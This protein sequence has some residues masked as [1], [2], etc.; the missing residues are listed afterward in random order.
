MRCGN[1]PAGSWEKELEDI[2]GAGISTLLGTIQMCVGIA[3]GSLW[4]WQ[5]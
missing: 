4:H 5:C 2:H 1:G 3:D